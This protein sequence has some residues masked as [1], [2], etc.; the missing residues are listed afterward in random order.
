RPSVSVKPQPLGGFG[1]VAFETGIPVVFRGK[2]TVL[3]G[4]R[5][6]VGRSRSSH[7]RSGIWRWRP[8]PGKPGQT[9]F[10]RPNRTASRSLGHYGAA[11]FAGSS[12]VVIPVKLLLLS[13]AGTQ[14]GS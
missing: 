3:S 1:P 8:Q 12:R 6:P 5:V 11:Q 10:V 13:C 9:V 4:F 2:S 7:H 14:F